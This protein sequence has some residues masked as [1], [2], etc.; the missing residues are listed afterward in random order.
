MEK[1]ILINLG[2]K[3]ISDSVYLSFYWQ[4]GVLI[5]KPDSSD[6]IQVE[7]LA[8]DQKWEVVWKQNGYLTDSAFHRVFLRLDQSKWFHNNFQ[9][10]F[11]SYGRSSGAY[12]M[13]HI[14]YVY[15]NQNRTSKDI[16]IRD[17]AVTQ[18]LTPLLKEY[19]A[20][21]LQHYKVD[22]SRFTSTALMARVTNQYNNENR[23]SFELTIMDDYSGTSYPGGREGSTFIGS[24]ATLQ[25]S[26]NLKAFVFGNTL[27]S[28]RL[29]TKFHML[30]SDNQ[31]P[32]IPTIDL[33]RND[34]ISSVTHFTDFYA[35]DD[36]TAEYGVQINQKLGRV[37]IQYVVTKPDTIGGVRMSVIPFN[38]DISGQSFTLQVW[39]NKNGKPDQIIAQ[40]AFAS[41]YVADR[42]KLIE[43]RLTK[44]VVVTD[45]F[46]VGWLQ[47]NEQPLTVG[48]DLNSEYGSHKA[49]YNLGN[50][51]V[52]S[53]DLRGSVMIRPFIAKQGVGIVTGAE[54]VEEP[55]LFYPNPTSGIIRWE[56][57]N[58]ELLE[59]ANG[60]GQLV[61]RIKINKGQQYCDLR[62]LSAGIYFLR[63]YIKGEWYS[64]KIFKI[65]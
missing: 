5:E 44:P 61:K 32:S 26:V 29:R 56:V 7:F 54:K 45:T 21:P 16:Y 50:E 64:Q 30:T 55:L 57:S 46:Y 58:I 63:S 36:G 41:R 42:T 47:V 62:E 15:L 22:P 18:P 59:V 35:Y 17:L 6:Y 53:T 8:A 13:W 10:R 27:D 39:N 1:G 20:M 11:R 4:S 14:D 52:N 28:A 33:T 38:K 40:N 49:F 37:A 25:K 3:T 31:N 43:F 65:D 2:L 19:T 9:F 51:W 23:T 34:T 48:Y 24:L 60:S 12:D